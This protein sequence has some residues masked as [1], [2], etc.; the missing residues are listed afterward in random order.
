MPISLDQKIK[1]ILFHFLEMSYPYIFLYQTN[2]YVYFYIRKRVLKIIQAPDELREIPR[3]LKVLE[4]FTSCFGVIF[5][6]LQ[7]KISLPRFL[8]LI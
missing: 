3:N 8:S 2:I 1:E 4:E 6:T 5:V 7:S